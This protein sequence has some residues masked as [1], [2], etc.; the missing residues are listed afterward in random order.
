MRTLATDVVR[1]P[2]TSNVRVESVESLFGVV[3][4]HS[5]RLGNFLVDNDVDFD[6]LFSL[7]LEDSVQTV[8]GV[9]GRRAT[10]I[11]FRSEPPILHIEVEEPSDRRLQDERRV[12]LT[13]IKIASRALSSIS[14][15]AY[16]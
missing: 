15:R 9:L 2:H 10:E 1:M 16:I 11:Q 8:F 6:S 5:H 14:E 3:R 7:A 4:A 13:K 12:N